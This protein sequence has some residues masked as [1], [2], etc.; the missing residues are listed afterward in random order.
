MAKSSVVALSATE[1]H[2]SFDSC[3]MDYSSND[4]DNVPHVSPKELSDDDKLMTLI[5][6][7]KF[8]GSFDL[9]T[10]LCQLLESPVDDVRKGR[11]L[12]T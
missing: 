12:I 3:L 10:N 11:V 2:D 4:E 9:E 7:Q 1:S 6:N 5:C 8:D